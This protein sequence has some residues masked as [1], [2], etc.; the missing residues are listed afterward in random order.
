MAYDVNGKA[1]RKP[2]TDEYRETYERVYGWECIYC[3]VMNKDS[4][5]KKCH[6]E[7]EE[8]KRSQI[9]ARVI[10]TK[11]NYH[12]LYSIMRIDQRERI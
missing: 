4:K 2:T 11:L 3:N 8:A 7:R 9:D 10:K 12:A 5:C 6:R 1:T